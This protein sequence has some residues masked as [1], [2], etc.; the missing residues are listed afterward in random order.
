MNRVQLLQVIN[1]RLTH[2][3]LFVEHASRLNLQDINVHAENFF[4]DLLNLV[5][6]HHLKNINIV[7]PNA[8]AIDL[9]CDDSRIAIQVTSTSD[10]SKIRHTHTRFTSKGLQAKYDRLVV[11]IVGQRKAYKET[12]L[13]AD[14][15]S[16]SLSD[17]VWDIGELLRMIGDLDLPKLRACHDFLR[18]EL[19]IAEPKQSNEVLTLVRLIEVLSSAE[20]GLSAGNNREDPD[21]EGKIRQRFADHAT[22]LEDQYVELHEIYG[23]ILSEVNS[24]NDLGH[25]RVRKLQIF[26]MNWSDRVLTECGGDP[27]AAL[28]L[29]TQSVLGMMGTRDAGFDDGAV[30]YYLIHQLIMCNVFPNKRSPSV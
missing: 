13:E 1:Y 20:D 18:D 8:T 3:R 12:A 30:R 22:F 6:G 4:R 2:L 29:L 24:Y 27:K 11:L 17:D 10:I 15:F 21:P 9:G 7:E 5:F 23:R 25:I 19:G 16:M 28:D 26:L 14:G